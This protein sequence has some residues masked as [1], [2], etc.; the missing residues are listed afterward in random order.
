MITY[1]KVLV[2]KNV[3]LFEKASEL[4]L[5]DLISVAEERMLKAGEVLLDAEQENHFLYV[6]LSGLLEMQS[7][8]KVLQEFGPRQLIGETTVF[9]PAVLSGE[10]RAKEKSFIL[11]I[12]AEQLYRVMALHPTLAYSFLEE[13][14]RRVRLSEKKD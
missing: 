1:E 10:I 11:Q 8:K 2:L 3:A 13:L 14:S 12:S 6:V 4:A 5:S 7:D 9:S